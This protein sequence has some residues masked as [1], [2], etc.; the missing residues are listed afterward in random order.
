MTLECFELMS[1]E[2][3][4]NCLETRPYKAAKSIVWA[5][6][7]QLYLVQV[8][9]ELGDDDC[10]VKSFHNPYEVDCV[11][12]PGVWEQLAGALCAHILIHGY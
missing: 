6:E 8:G 5:K 1:V 4:H 12:E 9:L 2:L 3:P 7:Y 11:P 10:Q